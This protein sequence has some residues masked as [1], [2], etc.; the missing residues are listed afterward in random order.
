M[1]SRA[2]VYQKGDL[3]T[4]KQDTIVLYWDQTAGTRTFHVTK[5]PL[6]AIFLGSLSGETETKQ[7][8]ERFTPIR[9]PCR[10]AIA[11]KIAVLDEAQFNFYNKRRNHEKTN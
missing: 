10:V 7:Y 4:I 6:N 3:V 2:H 1:Q 9:N 5:K 8:L 11:N